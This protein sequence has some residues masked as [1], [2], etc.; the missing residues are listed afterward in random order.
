M[1]KEMDWNAEDMQELGRRVCAACVSYQMGNAL[2]TEYRK[3]KGKAVG[4]HWARWGWDMISAVMQA[5]SDALRKVVEQG[6]E[7]SGD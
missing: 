3:M 4:E 1:S 5:H 6:I 7:K 2:Q